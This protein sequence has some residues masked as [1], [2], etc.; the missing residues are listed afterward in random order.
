MTA[1]RSQDSLSLSLPAGGKNAQHVV[2][3]QLPANG[4]AQSWNN[5]KNRVRTIS[6]I[7]LF[8]RHS[9]PFQVGKEALH[10][11]ERHKKPFKSSEL[12]LDLVQT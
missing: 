2:S 6:Q 12:S 7:S 8:V 10:T 3:L 4:D 1:K 11:V 9:E 5:L